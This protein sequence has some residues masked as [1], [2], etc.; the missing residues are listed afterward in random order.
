MSPPD[1][2]SALPVAF[3]KHVGVVNPMHRIWRALRAREIRRC[4]AGI[5]IDDVLLFRKVGNGE[6]DAGTGE[7]DKHIDLLDVDP[8]LGDV[9]ADIGLV[10]MVRRN[11]IDLPALRQQSGILDRHL[12]GDRRARAAD[13]GVETRL[14]A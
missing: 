11:Q 2:T 12:R 1:L 14:I 9:G 10:L 3:G 13:V 6:A 4:R 7:V 5:Q 8:L